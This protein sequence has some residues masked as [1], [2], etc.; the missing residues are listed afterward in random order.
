VKKG[1]RFLKDK[2]DKYSQ[3]RVAFKSYFDFGDAFED[4][5]IDPEGFLFKYGTVVKAPDASGKYATYGRIVADGMLLCKQTTPEMLNN[6]DWITELK[7]RALEL[8]TLACDTSK[9]DAELQKEPY[10]SY[11]EAYLSFEGRITDLATWQTL[12]TLASLAQNNMLFSKI[13]SLPKTFQEV[14]TWTIV[15]PSGEEFKCK[16]KTDIIAVDAEAKIIYHVDIKSTSSNLYDGSFV[17]N[18]T[19]YGY[20]EQLCGYDLGIYQHPS[21]GMLLKDKDYQLHTYLAV[22]DKTAPCAF[23]LFNLPHSGMLLHKVEKL[24]IKYL[25]YSR[26]GFADAS[27]SNQLIGI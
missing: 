13:L 20:D 14:L 4:M 18:A 21:Y 27:V 9:A 3:P 12:S 15:L 6:P 25:E 5:L 7:N 24:A 23:T 1:P 22:G 16:G 26:N 11:F 10:K 19:E 17:K 2:I 8:S